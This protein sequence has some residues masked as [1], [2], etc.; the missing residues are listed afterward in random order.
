MV[1]NKQ[2]HSSAL[3]QQDTLEYG[4]GNQTHEDL[5]RDND[6]GDVTV[7]EHPEKNIL[8]EA[9]DKDE[10]PGELN[11]SW[12]WNQEQ[13]QDNEGSV[14]EDD[15]TTKEHDEVSDHTLSENEECCL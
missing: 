2:D 7:H 12:F 5:I 1:I 15:L 11:V 13:K 9:F 6:V 8:T 10:N 14:I 4:T 3:S